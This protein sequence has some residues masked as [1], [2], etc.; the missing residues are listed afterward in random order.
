MNFSNGEI[1]RQDIGLLIFCT[2]APRPQNVF[3]RL[4]PILAT[5]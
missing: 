4:V 1:Q 5:Q 2:L 3:G